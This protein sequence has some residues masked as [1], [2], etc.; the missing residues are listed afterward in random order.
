MIYEP[1]RDSVE[2]VLRVTGPITDRDFRTVYAEFVEAGCTCRYPNAVGSGGVVTVGHLI[3]HQSP[4]GLRSRRN[5]LVKLGLVKPVGKVMAEDGCVA[6]R[7][8][9]V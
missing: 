1:A 5:E 4:S 6:E 3:R 7:W 2:Y 8:A 9:H